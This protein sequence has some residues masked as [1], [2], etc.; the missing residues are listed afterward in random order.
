MYNSGPL[1]QNSVWTIATE[2]NCVYQQLRVLEDVGGERA[3]GI[4]SPIYYI[5]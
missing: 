2:W 3:V 1:A 5:F 4:F